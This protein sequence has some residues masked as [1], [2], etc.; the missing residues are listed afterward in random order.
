MMPSRIGR[1][2]KGIIFRPCVWDFGPGRWGI[3]THIDISIT[4]HRG[5]DNG[6]EGRDKEMER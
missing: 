3:D 4:A 1:M 6:D 2:P 5:L